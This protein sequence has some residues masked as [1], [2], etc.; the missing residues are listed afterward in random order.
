LTEVDRIKAELADAKRN[1]ES[2]GA[3]TRELA[4]AKKEAEETRTELARTRYEPSPEVKSAVKSWTT[5]THNAQQR[6]MAI[7]LV[8]EDG[9]TIRGEPAWKGFM[10]IYNNLGEGEALDAIRAKFGDNQQIVSNLYLNLREA[11]ES[12]EA[13]E[14][15]DRA[16]FGE[17]VQ[18]ATADRATH[19]EGF[20]KMVGDVIADLV[21]K[22]PEQFADDPKDP[23]G[24]ALLKKGLE[25]GELVTSSDK[26]NTLSPAQKAIAIA[27]TKLRLGNYPRLQHRNRLLTLEVDRLKAENEQL[28]NGAT[29]PPGA[30]VSD[31]D[32]VPQEVDVRDELEKES[33]NWES[34]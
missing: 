27:N 29:A 33:K 26:F 3:L 28:R 15:E 31:A 24:N 22:T 9:T 6:I 12:R 14:A 8:G 32:I 20:K 10:S 16:N 23:D 5:K 11:Q 13:V 30:K 17:R 21:A 34:K 19:I 18:K 4:A 7:G 1:G 25:L 2:L